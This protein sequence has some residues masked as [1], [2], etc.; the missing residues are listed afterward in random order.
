M[1]A[2]INNAWADAHS[3]SQGSPYSLIIMLIVFAIIFYFMIFRPQQKRNKNHRE[4]LNSISKGDEVV[5]NGGLV[6]RVIRVTTAGYIFIVLNEKSNDISSHEVLIKHDCVTSI[7]PK[8][9]MKTL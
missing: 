7:L 5:T 8:G 4:L 6:G 2:F 1:N 3:I 9:T